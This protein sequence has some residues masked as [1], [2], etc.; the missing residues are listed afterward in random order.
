MGKSGGTMLMGEYRHNTDSKGRIII[1]AR[2][3]EELGNSIILARGLDGCITGY[4]HQ[5][6]ENQTRNV[7][8]ACMYIC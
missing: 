5:Q 3:R 2:F 6:W 7:N 8:P 4:T 1:P